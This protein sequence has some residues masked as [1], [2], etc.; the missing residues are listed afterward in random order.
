[1]FFDDVFVPDENLVG[2]AGDG[3]TQVGAELAFE[4]SGPER[5]LSSLRLFL[6]FLRVVGD[7]PSEA[8]KILI[9][10]MT[11]QMWTLRQMSL[12]IAGQL[13]AGQSPAVEAAIVKDLGTTLEQEI[14]RAIQAHRAR[15]C[16]FVGQRSLQRHA[17]LSAAILA[18]LFAARRHAG[19]FA[20]HHRARTGIA[21]G[22]NQNVAVG[23]SQ[24]PLFRADRVPHPS[25][26]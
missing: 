14:P 18:I 20:R 16:G 10:Q 23:D 15:R 12:S 9:G 7:A 11:A 17:F 2:R 3:W 21:L 19:N 25:D 24:N 4:R 26:R 1:M 8:E 13:A 5:Y 22:Q 6:E